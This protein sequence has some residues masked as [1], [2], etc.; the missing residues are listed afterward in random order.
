VVLALTDGRDRDNCVLLFI[1]LLPSN[2]FLFRTPFCCSTFFLSPSSQ[3]STSGLPEKMRREGHILL[4]PPR[5]GFQPTVPV[6]KRLYGVKAMGLTAPIISS[7]LGVDF[8]S[9]TAHKMQSVKA[10]TLLIWLV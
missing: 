3:L 5:L 6:V 10:K 1:S 8:S 2:P 7:I 9:S 4:S